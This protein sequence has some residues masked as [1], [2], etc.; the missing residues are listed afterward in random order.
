MHH[1]SIGLDY[2]CTK[3]NAGICE[4]KYCSKKRNMNIFYMQ[5]WFLFLSRL[6]WRVKRNRKIGHKRFYVSGT[7]IGTTGEKSL[8]CGDNIYNFNERKLLD[9]FK[10]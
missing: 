2:T 1:Q 8:D 4:G 10:N 5:W 9:N 6:G 7:M 3:Y